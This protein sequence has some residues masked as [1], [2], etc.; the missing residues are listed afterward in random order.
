MHVAKT[1]TTSQCCWS[2]K[3]INTNITSL[4]PVTVL[5]AGARV[6]IDSCRRC[7]QETAAA[8]MK[9]VEIADHCFTCCTYICTTV[10]SQDLH[11]RL[12][13]SSIA[14]CSNIWSTPGIHLKPVESLSKLALVTLTPWSRHGPVERVQFDVLV[15]WLSVLLFGVSPVWYAVVKSSEW[16]VVSPL[17]DSSG[18]MF[19]SQSS[20]YWFC[21]TQQQSLELLERF[22]IGID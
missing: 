18:R 16:V 15:C 10:N 4:S 11:C 20:K 22:S 8:D 13:K 2:V 3:K 6:T 9:I 17:F 19:H 12:C 14:L 5:A 7:E 21:H 1:T